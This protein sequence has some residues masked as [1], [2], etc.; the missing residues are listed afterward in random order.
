MY[1]QA[2]LCPFALFILS[3]YCLSFFYLRLLITSLVPSS[4]SLSFCPFSFVI[5]LSVRLL[6][7]LLITS[8]VPASFS[9][10]FCPFSFV[11]VLS[12]LL[13]FTASDYLFGTFK[14]LFAPLPFSFCHCIVCPSYIYG[15]WLPLWYLQASLCPFALFI[16]SLYCLSFF[17]LRLL[18]TSLVSSSFS[19]SFCPFYFVIVLSVLLFTASDYLFCTFKLLFVL[20]PFSF[21]HCIVC[22]SSIYGFWLPLL[23]LQAS[24]CPFALFILSL[25]CLSFF[26]LRLLITSLVSSS[27]SLSFCPFHFVIVMSVL[28][29][30]TVSDCLFCT[31]KLLFVLLPFSFCHCIVCPSSIY[32]FWLPLLYLQASLCPFALF[33]LSL[34]CLSFFYLRFLITSLVPSSFSLSFC[35]FH[36]VI[37]LYVLLLFTASDYLCCTF[38]LLFVLLPFSFCHCIVC[39]SSIYGFWLPHLYLQASLC[40]FALFILSLYCL[41]FFYLRLLITSLV[42]SS[43]SLSFCLFILSLYCLSFYLRLLITSFVSA[44]FSLSFCPFQ[45]VIVLSVLLFTG[46]DYL[47][48]IFKLLFVL[49]PFFFCHCIVCPSI[50]GFWLPLWYLQ[51]SL[52]PFTLFI[53]SLYCLSFYLRLLITSLVSSSLSLSFCPFQFVIVLSVLLL[54][55]AS[56]Y[57]F[58]IFKLLFVLLPFF[59]CHCIVCPSINGFWL[60]LWYLQA[61]LCPFALFILSLYCLSF[62]YLRL[63]ITSLVPSSFSL[64][65]CPF[66]FVIVL[67]VLL[68]FMASDYL[69]GTFKLLFVPL[70]FFF[71]HCIVCPSSIYG[72]WLPLWYLQA[73]LCPFVLFLFSLYCLSFF[74]LQLLITPLVS[75]SFSLSFCPFSFVIVLSILLLF[76]ASDYIFGIF[77]LFFV[78][79]PFFFCHCIVCPSIY[80]FWLPLWYLQAS[81]C[82]FPLFLLSLYCLSFFYLRLLITSLVS[83]SLSLSFC[84]FQFVIVLSVLLL[85][86]ASDYLF[87]IFKLLFVPLPFSF[88]HCIVCPSIYGFWLPL[89]YLQASLCPFALFSLSLYC[90]SF[91]YLRLLITSLVSSSFSLSF[92][93]FSFVIVLSVLLFR[94]LIT[95]LVSSSLSLSFFPFHF[96]IVLSVLLLFT[97]SDSLF[98]TFKLLFVLLPFSFCHCIVCPSSI[99]GF[100]LP[101]WYLQAS[102]CP[103]ALFILSL[104]CLSFFYL[105]LLI[106]SFVPSSFSLSLCPFS[107]VIVL[108]VLLLFTASDY[109]FCTFKLLFVL[110][111]FSFCHCIVCPSSIYGFWLPLWYLQASLCPFAFFLLSLY[112]LSV[113]YL[114]FWLPLL[115]LQA[116][117]CPFALFIL[118]LYCLS[119]FYLRLLI[120]SLVSSSFSL[121]FCPFHFV[122]VLSVLLL[123]TAS[124]YLFCTFKL[125]FVLLPFSFCHC[126]VCPSSIYGFWLP[127]WCLQASV[128]PFAL[129]ILSLYCLSFLYLRFWLP[130]WYLQASLCPFAF[131]LL[132]LYCLSVF[133]LRLLITSFV[134]SSFSLSFCPFHFVIVLSVLLLFTASDSLFGTFKLLFVLFALFILSLYCLSFFYLRLLITSFVPSSFSLSFCPFHFVIVLSV[135]LLFTASD[136][137]FCTFK[138]LFVLLP[139]SFCHCIVCRSSIYGFWLPLWYLQASLCPFALFLLSLYCLSVF[140]LRFWLPLLYLQASLCPFALFLLSLYCLS[141]F[142]LRLLIT[143][144]VPSSFCLPLCP[145]HFV[146]VLSVLLLF[147]ASDYLFGTCKLLF[148][149]LP[150]SFCHCIVCPSSIY[151]FWLPLW[152]LQASVCPF[153]LFLLSLYCLSFYLRL[154]ITSLVSSSFSLSFC[155]FHFVLVLSVLLFTASDYLFCTFKLLF[156]LLPFSFCHCIVCPSSIYGFWLPL[157]YLQASLCPFALFILSLYCLSFF[158]LRLLITSLVSSSFSLSF[159]PFHFVIVMS[160]L[161]LFTVSDYLFCTF[162]LLFVLLPF[163]FCHCIVCPSS[164]Y[165]FWLPL[166][167]LQASLCPF[168]LFL[169]SLYCLSFFYLRFLIT[170]LVPSSFSLSFCPFHFVIVL[171]VLLLFTA[172]DYLCCTFKLLFVLLPFSFCHCIVCPSSIYGFWLPLL[173]LQASLCPFALFI[174]SLYCLSVFYLRLLITSFVPSSFSLSFCLF[175]LSLYCLSFYLRLLITPLVSASFSLSFCPFQFVIV[176]SVLLFTG[177]DYLFGIFKLLFVLLPF[178]FCHCIVCPSIYGFW[179]PL[180]YLQASL[181]PFTLFILSLYCLSFYLRLLITSL[182]SSSLSLSFC[183]FQFVIVLSVLLL[184]TAS[185]YLFGIFKLLFVLLPFFF[186]HCIVCP[187]I[188]GFW[189]PLWYLQASLC[190]FALFILSLYC[191]SFFYLR[192]LITSLVPSSFSLSFCP[193]HFVIVLSVLLLFMASD[194]LFGTFKLLFVPLPFFFC[195]CIV[196]PS[197]IY[198]FWLP[199]WYLQASLCPFVLFLFSLYCLSFFYLQLLITPLVSSSFSLSFCPF[200]FVIVLSILLLFTASDYLFGIFKLFFVL[201]PF[202]FCHCIVCPSIYDFWLP[203]WYLQASLCPFP[204]FLLSLYCL[205]FF[206]LRLLITSLVPSRFSLSFCP[207]SFVIVLSVLLFTASDYLFGIFKLLFVLLPFFFFIL[208]SVLLFT[209]SDYLFGIFKPLFV[210]LTFSFCHFIVYPSSIYGFWLPLWYL[211]AS[212]CPFALF[213]LSLYCLS[214]SYLRLLITSLVSS[215]LSLSFCPFHF[216]IVLSVLLFTASDY[217]LG[218]Y[219]PLFVLLPF[220][221][222]HCIVCPSSIYVSDYLFGT[223]KLLFVPLP[224]FFCHCIVCPSSIYCF[225]LPLL[226]LQASL[227]PF[228]FFLCHCIVCRSSIDG[229]WLPLWYLQ[230]PLCPFALFLFSLYCLSFFYLQLL[231]TPLVFS[232]F[233]LS[234]CPFSFVIVLSILLLFTASDYLFGIFKLFFVLLPFFF[235]HCIVCPSIYDFWLP[236]WYLQASLC[237]FPLFLLSL[238]CLSFFYLRLLITSLVPSRFSLSFCPFSFVIVLSVLLFTASDYLFGIFKLLFVLLPF[239]FFILLSVLLFTTSDYLFGIFKPLFVLLTFSF[240]HC[241]VYPSSIY[242]FW[243]PLWYLQASL[244]PFALFILSLYCLSFSY[245][246]L[247]I[248]S[249]VSSSLSLSFCPFH[250]VIVLSVLLFTASD[251]LLGIYEPLFVLLPFS[252]CHCIVC[253]SSIYVSDYLF[254]TFKLLFVPLPF[255]FCHCIV[256]PSSIYCFWLPLLYLQAS[257][258]PFAFFLSHCIVCRSSIDGFWLPLWYLQASLCPFALFLFSLYCLSFF[259]LQLLITP[260]VFSSFSLSFCPFSF[261]I[262][263]SILLLFTASDYLFG[264]FK[265]F[266]VLLPFFFCHC[267]VCPSIYDFWLPLWY[268]QASLCP[269]PLFLLSLYCL[270]FFYLRLLITSLVPSR[271]SLSFCPFS[272]VIVLSVLLFTASDYLFGIFKL[273]FVLLPFF[274]FIL[275]SV[276]LFT[277][278]DYLF[279]IFKPLFVLLT[280]SFCHFIVYPSSIYGFW[281][282]LWYL[283]ASLCPFALFILS[284][285][286]LSFSY[287]RL[288]ITSLV[289]SSLSLSF[290][291]FHFVIVLSVLL[292]T[293]SDYL[294]GIYEPLFVLLPFSFCHCIVC[295]SSIYVSDYLFGT[296]KLLF[297]PLP[298]FFCHC[299]VCPS[300]IYCFWLPLLYLQASLCPFAFFLCHCIVCR[301]SI[302]GFWLPLWYLQASLCPFALFLFSLYCLSFFYLQLLI[303]PLVS[304]SL[305]LSFCPFC[306]HCIVCPS[307]IYGFWLPFWYL[308]ASLCPFALFPL[309]LYCLSFYLRFLITSLVSSSFSLSFCP[310]SFVIVL[311]VLFLFTASDYL[312]GTFKLL[313]VLLTFFVCHCIVCPSIYGF[314]LPL[315]YLQASLCPFALFILSLHCLSFFYL[316]LLNTSL[317]SSSF[318]LS[319][320]PFHFVIVLSVLL[321]FMASDYLFGIFKLLF[322]LLPFFFCYC[323]VCP[324]SI[325][326]FWLPLW[327][328][329]DYLCPIVPFPFVIVLSVLLLFTASDYLIGIFKL[330]F[331]LLSFF[332]CH[333]IV[334]PSIYGFWLPLWYLQA[335]LCPF[336]LFILSLYCLS[337][338]YLR[339]LITSLVP[340]SFCLSLCPFHF[341][342]VLSVLPLFTLLITSLVS[343]S[344]SLSFCL[345]SFGIVVSVRLLFT[346]SDY[347]FCTF[348]LLFVLLPLSFCHCIVCPS[349]IFDFWLPLWYLQASLCPFCP[350]HFVIVMSVLL[351]FT[352]SDYLFCTF[353][354]LFVLLPF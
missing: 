300:S 54:F 172:S 36:F 134:P 8:F 20:L 128:C 52:C 59:F 58:G 3:L 292:F 73:S 308:Q 219:E 158:Y 82:A 53:L 319:F 90:L 116:S 306:C 333:C 108:F 68:L 276:L 192:L 13:L 87:G 173:Y 278:S 327:Y 325:Y 30:F 210:L 77:K 201:L 199:L 211:Q 191:L 175:I 260:L 45:F 284:L 253:P 89:C 109:L 310:F 237:P 336:A 2:S 337:F 347:L 138:L 152:Y 10:S 103:F 266:F 168:A 332:F 161:L 226:Y 287:L 271:F 94:L 267:I 273:L 100:W 47:F 157:L 293:A 139:F 334:C 153:A 88:C 299:I 220:S 101:L 343:S 216:V 302:D 341:V 111:H 7:T 133:Y 171:Y 126:I 66:H 95:S 151:G 25:Y 249:L 113:F 351:L 41:S 16:L 80:G 311:S 215:S 272:F 255:F 288:L 329:Q 296:F 114:R 315:W 202:F 227:C 224:F 83:S 316:R 261:V 115:C 110:F 184:F 353:K 85:F 314:W 159:C 35:P 33:L 200:S 194:Y 14:L 179:L 196:C 262:V 26:Y 213:I 11:I 283:Q 286:C 119:F 176:L 149:L 18:I 181:C 6:F 275:L 160:V 178:F 166:L 214:F 137:L 155:P 106:T 4:F 145:F 21:C 60:P 246:R 188:N 256:C 48:G 320:C 242:G 307:S 42:P 27:F 81:L 136:Y 78:L 301:S 281:L 63:L 34:Y 297:V 277:T 230:A 205:S 203:L 125:L 1:L 163:S 144:L 304:S 92:C 86:T 64:S 180:W 170:S 309:S 135:L 193:F 44:S 69:F 146:I 322:V 289:S 96:V 147:T 122:I 305:S 321:Q 259:Y 264:I 268:L 245:L 312:F 62:F 348:K 104:Y 31:F 290:C 251:Y 186:C 248:T 212:L 67:S 75:S 279:G 298:F 29:L 349:S 285:Y 280:F 99:Y 252:F 350:F 51:A 339:L 187:S 23:Y 239:F 177:S 235:C 123:F 107:F 225:W 43:F 105:R 131:F 9:L 317:V 209:T 274:F 12:V 50:Y 233:S 338:F 127:L 234:F 291:P 141:F 313:F 231:I 208:L 132:S 335:S 182:V 165:G 229:F 189:L 39:P 232:S 222:C 236:L 195:H 112:C 218:I 38:K 197:S 121:S 143:S 97:A 185:D 57:L 93:P 129:F 303:T 326:G 72:F 258:C 162:K 228:A 167:Y 56:D 328:L 55:T 250:F 243:L 150:F 24:L 164:I 46:S 148:V 257:L 76:T 345:F 70:P 263:L 120:T 71:C 49:L 17:Y 142:Y 238:Y 40:P 342:I 102:L 198:G 294:L 247:L 169:L 28:L 79:L 240:C 22:P 156:V 269:F 221:F 183:P 323:I 74:Y 19:L 265:L 61:S 130:L 344:F 204:L 15:F 32:G 352:A 98:G 65:F 140:Y 340:S 91:S 241:I 330:L 244:C 223:F 282:P 354:L 207:F 117:L 206:Y 124:D 154:L 295:P 270:S 5:V 174:L 254:G 318:S 217:L 84:P 324:S 118:S 346:V 190:P 331:V 37:A